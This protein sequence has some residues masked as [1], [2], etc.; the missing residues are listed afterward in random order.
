[1]TN[2]QKLRNL[3][4]M[5]QNDVCDAINYPKPLY[6]AFEKGKYVMPIDKVKELAKLFNVSVFHILKDMPD[7]IK[8]LYNMK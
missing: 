2:I 3:Y 6:S 8:N 4:R 5:T 1:M 7:E